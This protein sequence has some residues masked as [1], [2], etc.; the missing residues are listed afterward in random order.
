MYRRE[1]KS[2][3]SAVLISELINLP[4]EKHGFSPQENKS[5][6]ADGGTKRDEENVTQ[7]R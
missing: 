7:G 2:L 6:T 1:D 4:T 3:P 5:S